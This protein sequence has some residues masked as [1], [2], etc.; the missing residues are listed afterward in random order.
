[1]RNAECGGFQ[2]RLLRLRFQ[3]TDSELTIRIPHSAFR[4]VGGLRL[5]RR[6]RLAKPIDKGRERAD[7]ENYR[8]ELRG[9]QTEDF[10]ARVVAPVLDNEPRDRIE[11]RV[12]Q[13]H[14]P[15]E[16]AAAMDQQQ[17]SQDQQS[18][19]DFVKLRRMQLEQR[20]RSALIGQAFGPH[21]FHW[22]GEM[23]DYRRHACDFVTFFAEMDAIPA[24]RGF[25]P[26]ASGAEAS[27]TSN[28]LA[29]DDA[30]SERVGRSPPREL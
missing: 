19:P 5:Q 9:R 24:S 26:A 7:E 16:T 2:S 27:Q 21:V 18:G 3:T 23:V 6:A 14:L 30:W 22:V 25:A 8:D 1:M 20:K 15:F 13:Y 12:G 28:R 10:A 29:E 17:H 11:H 4:L